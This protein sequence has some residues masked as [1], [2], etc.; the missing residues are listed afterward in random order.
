LHLKDGV[1][2]P[3]HVSNLVLT[4]DCLADGIVTKENLADRCVTETKLAFIPVQTSPAVPCALQLAGT[5]SFSLGSEEEFT[6]VV[7]TLPEP[8]ADDSYVLVAMTDRPECYAVSGAKSRAA[9]TV[10]IVRAKPGAEVKGTVQTI[11]FGPKA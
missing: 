7:I 10:R 6:E 11:A 4:G 3:R 1:I 2:E 9:A 8:F 5:D